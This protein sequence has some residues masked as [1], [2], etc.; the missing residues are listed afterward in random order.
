MGVG[1]F[2]GAVDVVWS[3]EEVRGVLRSVG[4]LLEVLAV[5]VG[6]FACCET[7][8]IDLLRDFGNR[9]SV[10]V[11]RIGAAVA[12]A[13]ADI[14]AGEEAPVGVVVMVS[15]LVAWAGFETESPHAIPDTP[16][17]LVSTASSTLLRLCSL[18]LFHA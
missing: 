3:E 7:A 9:K 14:S 18:M 11:E 6:C 15:A 16:I 5:V 12:S 1:G 8:S 2:A 4:M 17:D 10:A 13:E